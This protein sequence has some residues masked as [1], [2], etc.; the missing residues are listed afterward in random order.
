MYRLLLAWLETF[1]EEHF[2]T[3]ADATTVV[4]RALAERAERLGVPADSVFR[5][6]NGSPVDIV[7]P[8]DPSTHRKEFGLPLDMKIVADSGLDVML[9][10]E[11]SFNAVR[12]AS[13]VDNRLLMV[14]CGGH[15]K[16]LERL[17]L[18]TGI[19]SRFRH[20]GELPFDAMVRL[21][22][23][24]DVFLMGYPDRIANRGRWPG[25]M[26]IYMALGRPVVSNPVGE[27]KWLFDD[28]DLGLSAAETPGDMCAAI[29]RL[30]GNPD[31]RRHLGVNARSAAE[32]LSWAKMTDTLEDCY[33][34]AVVRWSRRMGG[35]GR[36]ES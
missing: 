15:R 28:Y 25:R 5:I 33:R 35:I 16:A 31:M 8:V 18:R 22:S 14:M 36:N 2:R 11:T 13:E 23:C 32:Q 24:A 26:G 17:A 27:M 7:M 1:Y 21:M 29:L 10:I 9:G 3:R 34:W 30:L 19:G 6:P 12:Q 20:F 4:S